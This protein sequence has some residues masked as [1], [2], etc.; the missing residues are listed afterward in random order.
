[1]EH[2]T[3]TMFSLGIIHH[4]ILWDVSRPI[5]QS[6]FGWWMTQSQATVSHSNW[7]SLNSLLFAWCLSFLDKNKS[8]KMR[9]E[10]VCCVLVLV[11]QIDF[12]L[13]CWVFFLSKTKRLFWFKTKKLSLL[14]TSSEINP[15]FMSSVSTPEMSIIW[16]RILVRRIGREWKNTQTSSLNLKSIF[17]VEINR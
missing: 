8:F 17:L 9:S 4:D 13:S 1:M 7:I 3:R 15:V 14:S 12:L 2:S 6:V 11:V 5:V 16:T 10:V